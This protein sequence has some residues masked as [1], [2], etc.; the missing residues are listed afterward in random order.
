MITKTKLAIYAR[1]Q[2]NFN[3]FANAPESDVRMMD[4]DDFQ[5]IGD[6]IHRIARE[7]KLLTSK[8]EDEQTMS[9]LEQFCDNHST[10]EEIK[11]FTFLA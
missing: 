1:Y 2:G 7:R 4:E 11:R 10:I 6:L 5:V 3:A 8:D 9:L